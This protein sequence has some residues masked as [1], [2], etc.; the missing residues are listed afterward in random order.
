[1][2]LPGGRLSDY[3]E[4]A[5]LINQIQV[6][7][8]ETFSST[9]VAVIALSQDPKYTSVLQKWSQKPEAEYLIFDLIAS[10]PKEPTS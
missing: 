3:V 1:V 9:G 5:S 4:K 10:F 6:R 2:T 8:G 7:L